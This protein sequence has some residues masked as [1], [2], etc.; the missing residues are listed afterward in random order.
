MSCQEL[1]RAYPKEMHSVLTDLA[2]V[3][4]QNVEEWSKPE[5]ILDE[6]T[7]RIGYKEKDE[8]S[9][10]VSYSNKTAFAYLNFEKDG[11]NVWVVVPMVVSGG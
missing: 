1:L 6:R 11:E 10:D 3:L 4:V 5:P 8:V 9:Y 2:T 7:G